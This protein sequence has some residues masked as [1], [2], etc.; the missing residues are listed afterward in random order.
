MANK[1]F[2]SWFPGISF[3]D[4]EPNADTVFWVPV[5]G[6]AYDDAGKVLPHQ[7]N[8]EAFIGFGFSIPLSRSS[9]LSSL[10][11]AAETQIRTFYGASTQIVWLDD[12]GL[13]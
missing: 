7:D 4:S 9:T 1:A 12:K 2:V 13:L 11:F 10:K 8:P 3:F 5:S 6:V